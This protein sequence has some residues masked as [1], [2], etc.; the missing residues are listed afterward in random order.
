MILNWPR[1]M[2][3]NIIYILRYKYENKHM[4]QSFKIIFIYRL[5]S[6][7]K[8]NTGADIRRLEF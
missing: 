6:I 3:L 7:M 1:V 8:W 5:S 4:F 2:L